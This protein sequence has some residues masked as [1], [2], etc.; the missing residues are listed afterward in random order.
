MKDQAA[1]AF[2]LHFNQLMDLRFILLVINMVSVEK[3]N[4]IVNL[5]KRACLV[6]DQKNTDVHVRV[7]KYI[8]FKFKS[9]WIFQIIPKN[10]RIFWNNFRISIQSKAKQYVIVFDVVWWLSRNSCS[11]GLNLFES[12]H[13]FIGNVHAL[14]SQCN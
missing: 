13:I 5:S 2:C 4:N 9:S 8:L 12:E 7:I 14:N 6:W 10:L 1:S 11:T 3:N